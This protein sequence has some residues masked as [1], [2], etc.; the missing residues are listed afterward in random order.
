MSVIFHPLRVRSVQPDTSEAV[1]VSFEVPEDLRPVFGFTQGQYLTLRKEIAGQDLRRSYSICAGV[2][3]G[4]LR[5]G[6]RKVQGGLFSNWINEQLKP[7]D[8]IN[9]MAPQ[10]PFFVPIEPDAQRHHL[11]IAGGSGIT[12][13]LSIMKTVLAREPRS[14]F[15]LIYGNRKLRSTMFKEELDDLKDRYMARLVLH[16][17]FSDEHTEMDIHTGVMNRQKIAEFLDGL[18]PAQQIDHAYICGPFQMNDEAEAALLAA[19]VPEDRIHIERFGIAQQASGQVGAVLHQAQPGDAAKARITIIRDGL[20]REIAF[21]REQPSI[22]DA[23]S[24]AGLEVPFS[25]TSGVCGTCRAKLVEGK[26]RMERNFALD[27]KEVAAG[28]VLTCQAHPVTEKVVLSFD[29]R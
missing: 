6:V 17:V 16:H 25:C 18:I 1:I 11:G 28:Y 13:I 26:V 9:V 12:P 8:T 4:E 15:T 21:S 10:G 19:G 27:K 5:V 7:G 2:D 24:A 29:E 3:E 14:R 23:A 22:L 20:Q